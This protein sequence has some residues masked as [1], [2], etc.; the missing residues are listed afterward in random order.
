MLCNIGVGSIY[1]TLYNTQ[2]VFS[3]T[4][5]RIRRKPEGD[6]R[7]GSNVFR[8]AEGDEDVGWLDVQV[9]KLLLV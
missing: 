6:N 7:R 3:C 5:A 9:R 2:M 1:F 8:F 4:C